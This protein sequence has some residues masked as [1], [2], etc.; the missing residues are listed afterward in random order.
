LKGKNKGKSYAVSPEYGD[1][2]MMLDILKA[3]GAEPMFVTIPVNG[4]WY[5][6]TGFPKKGRTD[7][8]KKVN[9]QI[10]AKG[11]QVADFSGHEYDPYFMK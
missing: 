4:K 11:F 3:A 5:D 9:K 8:Y 2:E 10:R 1:F 7:Y 6:Y